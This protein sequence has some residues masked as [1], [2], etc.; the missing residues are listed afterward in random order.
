MSRPHQPKSPFGNTDRYFRAFQKIM[1]DAPPKYLEILRAHYRARRHTAT[2]AQLADAVDYHL[3]SA[4]NAR[5]GTLAK[6]VGHLLGRR[7]M[8]KE[9]FWLYVLVYWGGKDR[10]GHQEFVLRPEVIKALRRLGLLKEPKKQPPAEQ[11]SQPESDDPPHRYPTLIERIGRD[12]KVTDGVKR[13]HDYRCQVCGLRLNLGDEPYAEAAHLK[14]LGRPHYGPDKRSNVL[15]LCP[16][17]HVLLDGGAFSIRE[18]MRLIGLPGRLH[19]VEGH[20]LDPTCLR[21]H[22]RWFRYE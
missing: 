19:T 3:W 12:T 21:Y 13:L 14:P 1:E 6:R 2:A 4:I 18:N 11:P 15:C 5:Y 17:H 20:A 22:R 9:G 8:P 16:N 7:S 10:R